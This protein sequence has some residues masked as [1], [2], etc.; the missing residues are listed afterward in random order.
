MELSERLVPA[1]SLSVSKCNYK[2]RKPQ[3]GTELIVESSISIFKAPFFTGG[4]DK[5][6]PLTRFEFGPCETIALLAID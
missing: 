5:R 3:C 4:A 6:A 1:N 2:T